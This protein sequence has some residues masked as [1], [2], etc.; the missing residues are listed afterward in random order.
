[1]FDDSKR[2]QKLHLL[3]ASLKVPLPRRQVYVFFS[4]ALNL[5]RITPPELRFQIAT[6]LP[7]V[8]GCGTLIDYRLWF[9]GVP[10]NW[11]TRISLWDPPCPF[12]DEQLQGPYASWVHLHRF[13][14]KAAGHTTIFDEVRYQLPFWP[15]GEI[16]TPLVAAQLVRIFSFRQNKIA[17]I[18]LG[19]TTVAESSVRVTFFNPGLDDR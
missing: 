18:L 13:K 14:K 9:F 16:A 1:M 2:C 3:K 15:A 5:E 6:P 8:M 11:K 17:E 4:D 19:D 12:I 10:F 7:I